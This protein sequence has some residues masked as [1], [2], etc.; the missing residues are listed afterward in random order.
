MPQLAAHYTVVAVDLPGH[1]FSDLG[2][3]RCSSVAGMSSALAALLDAIQIKPRYCVGHSAGAVIVCRM[4]LDGLLAP[5]AIVSINGAFLPLSGAAG[6]FFSPM[7]RL[8]SGTSF[9]PQLLARRGGNVASVARMIAT[10][11]STIGS[12]G[13]GL[14]ARLVRNPRH[15]AGALKMMGDWDLCRFE[16]DLPALTTPLA[17]LVGDNDRTVP[18]QQALLVKRRVAAAD[19]HRLA[20]VGHLAHE[21]MPAVVSRQILKIC[22][23]YP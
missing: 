14:Y 15:V 1:G 18:P 23:T 10:T 9:L 11:G 20:S 2:R 13:L 4:T 7:A 3:G 12:E 5:R 6:L 22:A 19:L 8:I 17:L 21:E 16:K